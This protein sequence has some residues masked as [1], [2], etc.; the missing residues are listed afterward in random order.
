MSLRGVGLRRVWGGE[1]IRTRIDEMRL[2]GGVVR[3]HVRVYDWDG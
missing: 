2:F 3:D 1:E